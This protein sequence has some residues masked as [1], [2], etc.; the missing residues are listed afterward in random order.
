MAIRPCEH[1]GIIFDA[2]GTGKYCT[3]K[4]YNAVRSQR[5]LAKY[6]AERPAETKSCQ[7]CGTSFASTKSQQRYCSDRCRAKEASARKNPPT[8]TNCVRCGKEFTR[9]PLFRTYCSEECAAATSARQVKLAKPKP[10]RHCGAIF[11]ATRKGRKA[12]CSDDCAIAGR[13]EGI[14]KAKKLAVATI[15]GENI[16]V[17]CGEKYAVT[18]RTRTSISCGLECRA[19][20]RQ[21]KMAPLPTNRPSQ[22]IRR[23]YCVQANDSGQQVRCQHHLEDSCTPR[24]EAGVMVCR[25]ER[26]PICG[27]NYHPA[28]GLMPCAVHG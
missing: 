24:T 25:V 12:Y 7:L 19:A 8:K 28:V 21:R 5:R 3:T 14:G 10:C 11:T 27:R 9:S 17:R 13:A 6:K 1:C 2:K 16:C 26:E 20:L 18:R 4:C 23:T 15:I 22:E